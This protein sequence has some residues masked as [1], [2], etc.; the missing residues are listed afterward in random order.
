MF[1]VPINL[2]TQEP[3]YIPSTH[4]LIKNYEISVKLSDKNLEVSSLCNSL[5]KLVEDIFNKIIN[6]K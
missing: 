6:L 4:K 5:I 1:D 3:S 2:E